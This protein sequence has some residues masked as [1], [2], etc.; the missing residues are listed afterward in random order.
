MPHTPGPW[1]VGLTVGLPRIF[2]PHAQRVICDLHIQEGIGALMGKAKGGAFKNQ[3]L[4]DEITANA[5][6]IAAAPLM[7]EA[8]ENAR[9]VMAVAL[10]NGTIGGVAL[11][12]LE[13]ANTA[14]TAATG[15]EPSG[16]RPDTADVKD[17]GVV[18]KG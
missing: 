17:A 10:K 15:Q 6:L 8:L 12:A 5:R 2:S 3:E 7:L 11:L 16:D 18:A 13:H 4:R 1:T 14:I 9:A